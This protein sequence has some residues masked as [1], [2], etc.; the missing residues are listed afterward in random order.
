MIAPV[1]A[2]VPSWLHHHNEFHFN[3]QAKMEDG[4][5]WNLVRHYVDF[6]NLQLA[7]I[8]AFPEAA[9]QVPGIK[10]TLPVMPGPVAY[11]DEVLTGQRQVLLNVY[12]GE[13]LRINAAITTSV[14]IRKFFYPRPSD[15]QIMPDDNDSGYRQSLNS[16][17]SG[18]TRDSR[19]SSVGGAANMNIP[20]S[21][22]PLRHFHQDMENQQPIPEHSAMPQLLPQTQYQKPIPIQHQLQV[23]HSA[24]PPPLLRNNSALSVA[25]EAP[26]S[27]NP[28]TNTAQQQAQ[29]PAKVKVWFGDSNCVVVRLPPDYNYHDLNAKLR[30][31]WALEQQV[32]RVEAETV[33]LT[34]EYKDEH[35]QAFYRIEGDEDLSIA[36]QRN[37]PKLTL[38]VQH[39]IGSV[40]M[41]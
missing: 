40:M 15:T 4:N 11:V 30:E 22:S 13:V 39:G 35:T 26:S 27:V 19:H 8:E 3:V 5:V 38:R 20:T 14:P 37:E 18:V 34:I 33:E 10:R 16:R 25:S 31:R 36:R 23:P 7:L 17:H 29:P 24:T 21:Q 1:R 32:D 28:Y 9:G 2:S 6:Y 41:E 12:M